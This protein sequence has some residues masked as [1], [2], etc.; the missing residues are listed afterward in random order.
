MVPLC[1]IGLTAGSAIIIMYIYY[2]LVNALSAHM[3][4]TN[5]NMILYSVTNLKAVQRRRARFIKDYSSRGRDQKK[6]VP[7]K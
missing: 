7:L 2:A 1:G 6:N 5:I 3:V 4:H